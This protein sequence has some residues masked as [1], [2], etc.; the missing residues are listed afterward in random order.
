MAMSKLVVVTVDNMDENGALSVKRILRVLDDD[1]TVIAERITR[2]SLQ[3]GDSLV[4]EN[5]DVKAVANALWNPDRIAKRQAR[6]A[7]RAAELT[8]PAPPP[9]SAPTTAPAP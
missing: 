2:R 7:A 5:A 8:A 3:P 6:D 1:G 9:T 4:G